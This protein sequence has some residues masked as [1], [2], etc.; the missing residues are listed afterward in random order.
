MV[1]C[2][3]LCVPQPHE[4]PLSIPASA[5]SDAVPLAP[6]QAVE[7]TIQNLIGA[8]M[9]PKT[10][11]NPYLGFIY[12]SFQE[13]ATKIS[14]GATARHASELCRCCLGS[15]S[16]LCTSPRLNL[17][18][19][20][21]FWPCHHSSV[22]RVRHNTASHM[23]FVGALVA[24]GGNASCQGEGT[25]ASCGGKWQTPACVAAI[26]SGV[27][28]KAH[29]A[30]CCCG[31]GCNKAAGKALP[32]SPSELCA[33]LYWEANLFVCRAGQLEHQR[34]HDVCCRTSGLVATLLAGGV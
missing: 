3:L 5:C 33:S 18:V 14:H 32:T 15:R 27:H 12:T 31:G 10:E 30:T 34:H 13:R 19:T 6:L 20:C 17:L 9:D 28:V 11:N 16:I 24:P 1:L 7:V 8:G 26:A 25:L 4:H 29:V 22:H 21:L 23:A 2:H